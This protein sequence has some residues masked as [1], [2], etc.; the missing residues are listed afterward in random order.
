MPFLKTYA[1]PHFNMEKPFPNSFLSQE[2]ASYLLFEGTNLQIKSYK[3]VN[4]YL[5]A[6]SSINIF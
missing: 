5:D 2:M 1:L 4:L 6:H 3:V